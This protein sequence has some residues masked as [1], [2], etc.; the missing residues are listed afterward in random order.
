MAVKYILSNCYGLIYTIFSWTKFN[1]YFMKLKPKSN[2][3]CDFLMKTC[4]N[5]HV[6]KIG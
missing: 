1:G 2:M 6:I 5:S 4:Y 3:F